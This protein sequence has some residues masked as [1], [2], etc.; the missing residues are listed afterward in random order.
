MLI[1]GTMKNATKLQFLDRKWQQK[2]N[3]LSTKK[4]SKELT[5]EERLLVDYQEQMKKERESNSHADTYNKLKSGGKLTS[6]EISYLEQNDPEALRRYREDQVEQETY[7]KELKN[8]KS[9]D[10]VERVKMNKLGNFSAYG[11]KITNDPYIPLDKKVELMN[12]LN[13]KLCRVKEVH[14]EF[15]ASKQYKEMTTEAELTEER[16]KAIDLEQDFM[17]EEAIIPHD[18]LFDDMSNETKKQKDVE[19]DFEEC[20]EKLKSLEWKMLDE[21]KS[22]DRID[23]SI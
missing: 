9:K 1:T 11:K 17:Q 19:I 15:I 2:K 20:I 21:K 5:K 13:D 23:L 7:E 10:E 12:Q 22:G 8:C 6:E 16:T 18:D 14:L 4:N 3:S